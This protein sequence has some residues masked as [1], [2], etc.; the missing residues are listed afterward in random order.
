MTQVV[1]IPNYP[2]RP[3]ETFMAGGMRHIGS[4]LCW[5][6]PLAITPIGHYMFVNGA[7][8]A[9]LPN[10]VTA[11]R[12]QLFHQDAIGA[13]TGCIPGLRIWTNPLYRQEGI[14]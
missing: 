2:D 1:K 6:N 12:L 3:G 5:C 7:A 8:R 4:P 13:V 11:P 10:Q 14:G 9:V